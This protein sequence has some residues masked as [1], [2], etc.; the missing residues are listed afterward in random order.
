ME[1]NQR[2][3]EDWM[4]K[5]PQVHLKAHLPG[6]QADEEPPTNSKTTCI[7]TVCDFVFKYFNAYLFLL[8]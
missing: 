8:N 4:W 6:V 3:P 5:I 2:K 7:Y 1:N